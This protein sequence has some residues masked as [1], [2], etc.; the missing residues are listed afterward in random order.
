[1]HLRYSLQS[2]SESG[3]NRH[4]RQ[5]MRE[6]GIDYQHSTPQ[7]IADQWC[8]WNCENVPSPLPKYLTA[9]DIKPVDTIGFGLSQEDAAKLTG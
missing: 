5:V 8:F 4:P 7:S 2:A 3:E 9:L 6:L 1:M